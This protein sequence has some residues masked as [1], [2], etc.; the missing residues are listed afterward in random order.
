VNRANSVSAEYDFYNDMLKTIANQYSE[1]LTKFLHDNYPESQD[2][3]VQLKLNRPQDTD[4]ELRVQELLTKTKSISKEE[5]RIWG[6]YPKDIPDGD[7]S[8]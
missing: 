1:T 5:L 8:Y 6:E 7:F 4:R 3:I 2:Y